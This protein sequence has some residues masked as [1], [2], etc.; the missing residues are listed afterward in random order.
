MTEPRSRRAATADRDGRDGVAESVIGPDAAPVANA[1]AD[2]TSDSA[3]DSGSPAHAHPGAAHHVNGDVDH[4]ADPDV[5]VVP[6][7]TL[8]VDGLVLRAFTDD[9]TGPFVDAVR[10]SVETVGQW[11]SWCHAGYTVTEA[12]AWFAIA[13]DGRA[14]VDAY[15]FGVFDAVTGAFVGGAGLNDINH[16]HLF[17]NLGYWVR[18]S[19]QRQGVA[20][21]C[22]HALLP[23]A[24]GPLGLR[25]VEIVTAE[26]NRPSERVARRCGAVFEAVA[27]NRVVIGGRSVSA[28]VFSIIPEASDGMS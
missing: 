3:A 11:M 9:D 15:E 4:D 17:C 19:R 2:A 6:M 26:G 25:R 5:A 8:L 21:R 28:S 1:D 10:E 13:R 24:F 14:S 20:S 12:L 18:Q 7:P 27:R 23:L 22:V 16:Q